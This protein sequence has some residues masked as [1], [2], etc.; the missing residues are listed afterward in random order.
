MIS[1]LRN[2]L[3]I[4][5]LL[6]GSAVCLTAAPE[7]QEVFTD[8]E[9]IPEDSRQFF[10]IGTPPFTALFTDGFAGAGLLATQ[11]AHSP[12]HNWS[13]LNGGTGV[14]TFETPAL[15]VEF[16]AANMIGGDGAVEVYDTNNNLLI[17]VTDLPQRILI[18]D[19]PLFITFN[20][21]NLQ[22]PDGIGK[23]HLTDH[24]LVVFNITQSMTVIDDFGFTPLRGEG[25]VGGVVDGSGVTVDTNIQHP[26]GNIFDQVLLTGQSVTVRAGSNKITRVSFVDENDDIVQA[27]FSG[28][29]LLTINLDPATFSGPAL[30]LKYNQNV[31]YVKGRP[32]FVI[33]DADVNTFFS[34]FSVGSIN[35]VNQALF[36]SGEV[37]DAQANATLL[38]IINSTA[39]AAINCANTIFAGSSGKIGIDARGV[40][41]GIRTTI[42][43]IDATGTANP[44]LIVGEGSFTVGGANQGMRITGGDLQQSNGAS[45]IV[46]PGA[47]TAA[48]FTTL[49]SQNNFKSDETALPTQSIISPFVNEDGVEIFIV[50]VETTIN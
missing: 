19:N 47:S 16:Y 12:T 43:D 23:I 50:V 3:F 17:T 25:S 33:E 35:A 36:P 28:T 22:A 37:Y 31:E 39:M 42:G 24:I 8:F 1:S 18:E 9:N 13:I 30:P 14:I 46:S 21:L 48:G 41:V 27:E 15:I 2:C 4:S 5:T 49:I 7:D 40:P 34:L 44:T 10:S 32:S 26:N 29:G 20:A 11:L 45:V 38:E 6:L